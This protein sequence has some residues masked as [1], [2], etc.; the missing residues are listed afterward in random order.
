[1]SAT[2][3]T[4]KATTKSTTKGSTVSKSATRK[5]AVRKPVVDDKLALRAAALADKEP[6]ALHHDMAAWMTALTGVEVSPKA[7]QIVAVLR[8]D[9]QRSEANKSRADY[10][11]LDE[12]IVAQRSVH[13]TQAHIDA[14]AERAR[15]Q[16]EAE[17]AEKAGNRK[18]AAAKRVQVAK[19]DAKVKATAPKA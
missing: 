15:L 18:A 13:M 1:M 2:T 17:K 19:A 4:R 12:L 3:A 10:K 8:M 14:K 7:A 5:P 9:Y 11:A 16:A 6:T